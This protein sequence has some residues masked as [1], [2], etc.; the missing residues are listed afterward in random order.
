[1]MLIKCKFETDVSGIYFTPL[2]GYS[3]VHGK[4]SFWIGWLAWLFSVEI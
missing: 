4:K 3:N 1:M 2:I